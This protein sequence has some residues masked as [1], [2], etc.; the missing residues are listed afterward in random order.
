MWKWKS[1]KWKEAV[2]PSHLRRTMSAAALSRSSKAESSRSPSTIRMLGY[3]AFT[4]SA[5]STVRTSA[6]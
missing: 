2:V 6:E 5:F 1:I 4:C 3:A